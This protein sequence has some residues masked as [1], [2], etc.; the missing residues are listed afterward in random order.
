MLLVRDIG[1]LLLDC[2]GWFDGLQN[3]C[4]FFL[5][6]HGMWDKN[7]VMRAYIYGTFLLLLRTFCA[8]RR[9]W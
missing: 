8:R 1:P 7:G 6:H 2:S 3:D 4:F 5:Y 9:A